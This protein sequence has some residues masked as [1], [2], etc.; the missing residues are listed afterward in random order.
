MKSIAMSQSVQLSEQARKEL[1]HEVKETVAAEAVNEQSTTFT[2]SQ[3]WNRHRQ[4]RSASAM[5]RKWNL[6]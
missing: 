1:A 5:I 4:M 2:A 3:M 6:N